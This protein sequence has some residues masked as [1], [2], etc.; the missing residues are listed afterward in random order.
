MAPGARTNLSQKAIK[1]NIEYTTCKFDLM[2]EKLIAKIAVEFSGRMK[3]KFDTYQ[4]PAHRL[5][6]RG[7]RDDQRAPGI[8]MCERPA[9]GTR[10][11]R[12]Q[13]LAGAARAASELAEVDHSRR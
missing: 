12:A 3:C 10:V 4:R 7:L 11:R 13:Q 5:C 2:K 1:F 6:E 9:L 8:G